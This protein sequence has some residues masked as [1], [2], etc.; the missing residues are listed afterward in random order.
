MDVADRS[1]YERRVSG[2]ALGYGAIT[3]VLFGVTVFFGVIMRTSQGEFISVRPDVLYEF[4]TLHSIGAG[5]SLMAGVMAVMWYTLRKHIDM[6]MNIMQVV[7]GIIGAAV[8]TIVAV[9]LLGY[10][11]TG[12][13]FLYPLPFKSA[14][15]WYDFA[16]GMW[17]LALMCVIFAFAMSWIDV[18]RAASKKYG[19]SNA[20]GW[21]LISGTAKPENVPPPVVLIS[22]V[23]AACGL[24]SLVAGFIVVS[25][26]LIHWAN[27]SYYLDYLFIKN[28]IYY[29]GHIVMNMI[30]Y[31]CA[32]IVYE[33]MPIYANRPWKSNKIVAISWNSAFVAVTLAYWHH[34]LQD[35]PQP[36][37][38]QFLGVFGSYMAAFPATVVTITGTLILIYK[39]GMKW[40]V[41][42][43]YMYLGLMGW[44]IGGFWAVMD[45]GFNQAVH[46]TMYVPSHFHTYLLVGAAF[47]FVGGLYHI[48]EE[49]GGCRDTFEDKLGLWTWFV[50]G[51]GFVL[52]FMISGVLGT[53]RRYAV[54][55][56]GTEIYST[57]AVY[58]AWTV[59]FGLLIATARYLTRLQSVK[60]LRG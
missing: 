37:I 39:S 42:P 5:G 36:L 2:I 22:T 33:L 13:T 27:P 48:T 34:L 3:L 50:G 16:P 23:T 9:T 7:F 32:A 46:N 31:M 58:F 18:I 19:F 1:M 44:A 10:Y 20:M 8:V 56:P 17:L 57:A 28:L 40:K 4:M 30:M 49:L 29:F 11:G 52:W 60:P 26:M 12:W 21:T 51:Y 14:G 6:S 25:L 35:F 47:I 15:A 41:A 24:L 45:A 43:L 55:M 38:F 53:P 59:V 54:Q